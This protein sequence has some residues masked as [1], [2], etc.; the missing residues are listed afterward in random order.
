MQKQLNRFYFMDSMRSVLMMLGIVL[1][2]ANIF[3]SEQNWLIYSSN[4][5]VIADYIGH[6]IHVFR[7]PTFFVISGFFCVL[8]IRKYNSKVFILVRMKKILIPLFVTGITLNSIQATILANTGFYD[9]E[10]WDYLSNGKWTSHLWFLINLVVYFIGAALVSYFLSKPIKI[11][12]NFCNRLFLL[13]P[14]TII[15]VIMPTISIMIYGLNKIGFPLYSNY[16]GVFDV[17][18]ICIYLP[19]FMFGALLGGNYESLYKFSKSNFKITILLLLGSVFASKLIIVSSNT[20]YMIISTY[21]ENLTVWFS[22]VLCFHVFYKYFNSPSSM[23]RFLSDASYTVYLFH[24]LIVISLGIILINLKIQPLI[25]IPILILLTLVIT[26]SIHN[27]WI[28][29]SKW[30]YLLFNGK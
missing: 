15:I 2:S 19:Y 8:T 24:H 18:S 25:A 30:A 3:N 4:T 20:Y 28:S 5:T 9:F 26:L 23:W 13:I 14:L 1:H 16:Y 17:F 21:V 11:I 22:I 27:Y 29:K 6:I 7:M 10:I 12:N